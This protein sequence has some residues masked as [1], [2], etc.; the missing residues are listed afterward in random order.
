M[1]YKHLEEEAA[2]AQADIDEQRAAL[3]A[4]EEALLKVGD[5]AFEDEFGAMRKKPG[6]MHF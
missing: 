4:E 5:P 2:A 6:V 3:E 1:V